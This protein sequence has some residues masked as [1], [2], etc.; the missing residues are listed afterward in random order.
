M[1]IK[2]NILTISSLVILIVAALFIFLQKDK[3]VESD[4]GL[5]DEDIKEVS[6]D[7]FKNWIENEVVNKELCSLEGSDK[8][9][10]VTTL[11][12]GNFGAKKVSIN[13]TNSEGSSLKSFDYDGSVCPRVIKNNKIYFEK[14]VYES[15]GQILLLDMNKQ[16]GFLNLN[17]GSFGRVTDDK[18]YYIYVA[19][20]K[21]EDGVKVC[22]SIEN[23]FKYPR[24]A[25]WAMNLDTLEKRV[26]IERKDKYLALIDISGN[27]IKYYVY[28]VGT[29]EDEYGCPSI[30]QE[31]KLSLK[32]SSIF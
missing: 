6:G 13:I 22:D 16:N 11:E 32:F 21:D 17:I 23:S 31:E 25:I 12:V 5:K 8:I 4:L 7:G 2:K 14:H 1:N 18:N 29:D 24:S 27:D 19:D 9:V 10:S 20:T 30:N 15:E 28:G 26:L 3:F